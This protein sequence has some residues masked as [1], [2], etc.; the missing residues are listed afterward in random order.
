MA[1][2]VHHL[3]IDYKFAYCSYIHSP[4]YDAFWKVCLAVFPAIGWY[5]PCEVHITVTSKYNLK[6][7][8]Y[9]QHNI[10]III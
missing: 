3:S 2:E 8:Y 4:T 6:S 10:M 9:I 7:K 1:T 5:Y